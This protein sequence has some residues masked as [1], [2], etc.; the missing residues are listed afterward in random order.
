MIRRRG[1]EKLERR[2]M[3]EKVKENNMKGK[4][5]RKVNRRRYRNKSGRSETERKITKRI[6]EL[7][8]KK[9]KKKGMTPLVLLSVAALLGR[10]TLH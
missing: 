10:V 1:E 3:I 6:K 9:K 7:Q 4:K 8:E 5:E 2:K